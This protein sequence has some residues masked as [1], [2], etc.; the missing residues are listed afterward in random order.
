MAYLE[1]YLVGRIR[2][3][4]YLNRRYGYRK[5]FVRCPDPIWVRYSEVFLTRCGTAMT[6]SEVA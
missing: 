6:T 1:I 3:N 2:Q 4:R 5:R